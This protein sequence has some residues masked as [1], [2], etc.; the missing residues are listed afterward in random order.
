MW[1]KKWLLLAF[2]GQYRAERETSIHSYL[3]WTGTVRSSTSV[4]SY[5][6]NTLMFQCKVQVW[7]YDSKGET[8][9]NIPMFSLFFLLLFSHRRITQVLILH[10]TSQRR[11]SSPWQDR[12]LLLWLVIC[13]SLSLRHG[14]K[15][16]ICEHYLKRDL[17]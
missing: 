12:W 2:E 14:T 8:D 3:T 4:V 11:G 5:Y 10:V 1:I 15:Y 16:C 7:Q 13:P 17:I 9:N 6:T